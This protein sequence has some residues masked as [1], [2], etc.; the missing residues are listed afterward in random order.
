[1]IPNGGC[2]FGL[3]GRCTSWAR[4]EDEYHVFTG[5]GPE[6]LALTSGPLG[7]RRIP[8]NGGTPETLSPGAAA[9]VD[10]RG[11]N[12]LTVVART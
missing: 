10:H 12:S 3:R 11:R 2:R 7:D 9:R 8:I 6:L 1:M 4:I 5:S